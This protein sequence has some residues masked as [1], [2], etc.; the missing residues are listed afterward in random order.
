[1][2]Y[3]G[4]LLVVLVLLAACS[5]SP[6]PATSNEANA[7]LIPGQ[8]IVVLEQDGLEV[9]AEDEAV[10]TARI[11]SVSRELGVKLL[12]P[13]QI[14]N[15]FS[16]AFDASKLAAVENNARV[17]YVE[18][19][20]WAYATDIQRNPPSWGLDRIDSRALNGAYEYNSTG[21]GVNV[22]VLDTGIRRS[23]SEFEGRAQAG[24]DAVQDGRG[25][26]DCT[27]H[28]THVA[29]TIGGRTYGVAKRANLIPVRVL[30]CEGKGAYS[31][32]IASVNW[33]ARNHRKPA[34]V[35]MSLSGGFS[36]AMDGAVN[37]SVSAGIT[38]VVAAGNKQSNACDRSPA[39]ASSAITVGA[40]DRSDSRSSFS[41]W[42]GCV[43]LFAPG[44]SILSAGI[45]GNTST[46]T[47]SGTSMATPH[48]TG[49]VALIL[50]TNPNVSPA[51]IINYLNDVSSKDIVRDA[52]PGSP[53]RLLWKGNR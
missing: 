43:D 38:Y 47:K 19:D 4:L 25:S 40:T 20:Q 7:D 29:G 51:A 5:S 6:E 49:V 32:I 53:N 35:N 36:E 45:N 27:G 46:S 48:V 44:S 1:M 37:S 16:A 18:Q 42:G 12:E 10:F 11:E 2:R 14:I 33:V 30:N 41:N 13:L 28:G 17:K 21:A 26:D 39:R 15:G 23:H 52:G 8:Y 34:V 50:E 24:A 9:M 22:Y 3:F 31:R